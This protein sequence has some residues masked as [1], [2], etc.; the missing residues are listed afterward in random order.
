MPACFAFHVLETLIVSWMAEQK[1][2][3]R[4]G[5]CRKDFGYAARREIAE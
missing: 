2:C 5:V 1:E 3:D 4:E